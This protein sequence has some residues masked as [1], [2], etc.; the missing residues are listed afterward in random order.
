MHGCRTVLSTQFS[1]SSRGSRS[2]RNRVCDVKVL[3]MGPREGKEKVRCALDG[4]ELTDLH[5]FSVDL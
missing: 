4:A 1:M 3:V 2:H 5:Y